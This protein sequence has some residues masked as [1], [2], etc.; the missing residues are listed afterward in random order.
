MRSLVSRG[1]GPYWKSSSLITEKDSL[2]PASPD[3]PIRPARVRLTASAG[4][5]TSAR[6]PAA[7]R[8]GMT[9]EPWPANDTTGCGKEGRRVVSKSF[10][11]LNRHRSGK[12]DDQAVFPEPAHDR[13]DALEVGRLRFPKLLRPRQFIL[14]TNLGC[15][16][17]GTLL[18]H[19]NV[20]QVLQCI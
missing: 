20:D 7:P 14:R 15:D 8:G 4:S 18:P 17:R 6:S 11:P 5:P 12:A 10:L 2:F 9:R 3:A 13:L 1:A 16:D 19:P